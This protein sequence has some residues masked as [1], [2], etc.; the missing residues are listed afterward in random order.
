MEVTKIKDNRL[1]NIKG[2][3][4]DIEIPNELNDYILKGMKKGKKEK[5]RKRRRVIYSIAASFL[6]MVLTIS[7]RVSPTF[8]EIIKEI[9]LG[10]HIVNLINYDKGLKLAVENDF[11]Q[12]VGKGKEHD[13]LKFSVEEIIVDESRMIIFYSIENKGD[14][15][16]VNL[17]Y[18]NIY[19]GEGNEM[20][21][22][23][24]WGHFIDKNMMEKENKKLTGK[25]NFNFH[26]EEIPDN[27]TIEA[28]LQESKYKRSEGKPLESIYRIPFTIDKDKFKDM[29]NEYN[30]NK[31]ININNQ[32]IKINKIVQY[33]TR[34]EIDVEFDKDN[35]KKYLIYII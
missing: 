9:P 16:Y 15:K 3:Y 1:K 32:K 35:T 12:P 28:K 13:N 2:K 29:K 20:K 8:A 6:I 18:M 11:I 30:L 22:S 21:V 24:S 33:P 7:I 34:I 4:E 23:R 31:V 27:I 25:V 5:T 19:D 26:K 17:K 14:H 10:E